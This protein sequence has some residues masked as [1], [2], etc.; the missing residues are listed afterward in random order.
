MDL[1]LLHSIGLLWSSIGAARQ[2]AYGTVDRLLAAAVVAW[3]NLV[4]TGLLLSLL[5]RLGEPFWFLGTSGALALLTHLLVRKAPPAVAPVAPA[6]AI[7]PWLGTFFILGLL[8]LALAALGLAV[9]FPPGNPDALTHHLPRAMYYL[10]QNSLA[11]FATADLR[12]VYL[13]FNYHL[14]QVFA[15]V[16]F[17]PLPCL[18]IFNLLAW[19]VAGGAVHQ[20]CQLCGVGPRAALAASWLALTALPVLVPA[21]VITETLTAGAGLLCAAVFSLRWRRDGRRS[22]ALLAG[23]TLGLTGGSSLGV[24]LVAPGVAFLWP[25]GERSRAWIPATLLAV[26]FAAPFAVI[27]FAE[28]PDWLARF[29]RFA[30]AQPAAQLEAGFWLRFGPAGLW[31]VIGAIFCG[32]WGWRVPGPL[33]SLAWLGLS[34]VATA[35]IIPRWGAIDPADFLPAI[36]LLSPCGAALLEAAWRRPVARYSAGGILLVSLLAISSKTR[37]DRLPR[38]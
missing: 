15:L 32:V 26:A 19:G 8:P 24:L 14:L 2:L 11:H 38:S 18:N 36:L 21:T 16:Y 6:A 31:S 7:G 4:A 3:G 20:L 10:G 1:L 28:C 23:L 34:G 29:I 22:D 37:S 5:N 27:N 9:I 13:P 33:R 17:P 25:R 12:Q 35:L 30:A